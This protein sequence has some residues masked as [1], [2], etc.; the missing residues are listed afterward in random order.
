MDKK[1]LDKYVAAAGDMY[2]IVVSVMSAHQQARAGNYEET[3]GEMQEILDVG[4]SDKTENL[5]ETL[6]CV[7]NAYVNEVC[8]ANQK[9]LNTGIV[10]YALL[11]AKCSKCGANLECVVKENFGYTPLGIEYAEFKDKD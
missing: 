2:E 1:L 9:V 4:G 8:D 5:L 7:R 10:D 6:R 11:S 3:L